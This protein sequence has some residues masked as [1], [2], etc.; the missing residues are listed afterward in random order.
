[1]DVKQIYDI[2]LAFW[3][4]VKKYTENPPASQNEWDCLTDE[5]EK[6]RKDRNSSEEADVFIKGMIIAW[7]DY[8]SFKDKRNRGI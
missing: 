5:A 6:L 8:L 4:L 1:M 7:Y 2:I 3:R